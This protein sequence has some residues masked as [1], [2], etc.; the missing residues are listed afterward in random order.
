MDVVINGLVFGLLLCVLIG[1]VFFA[2]IQN[3]IEKGFK[4]G[5]F[6]AI[7]IAVSDAFYILVTY[8]GISQLTN[9]EQFN[10]WLGGLGVIMLGF[11]FSTCL[12]RVCQRLKTASPKSTK[13]FQQIIKGFF[14][15]GVNPLY[16]SSGLA[17]S[18]RSVLIFPIL[19]MRLFLS[20]LY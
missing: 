14:L 20:F 5:F 1:P 13:W 15:N 2:L 17:L 9:N 8:L 6:M 18:V 10:M 16:C 19:L 3:S 4:A 7:G 11:K 12:S